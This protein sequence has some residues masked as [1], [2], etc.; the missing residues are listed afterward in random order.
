MLGTRFTGSPSAASSNAAVRAVVGDEMSAGDPGE[1]GAGVFSA[2]GAAAAVVAV[3]IS[4]LVP[5][6]SFRGGPE[7]GGDSLLLPCWLALL[8]GLLLTLRLLAALLL[9]LSQRLLLRLLLL[10][11]LLLPLRF[12]SK[13]PALSSD[14]L[15]CCCC[16]CC[17]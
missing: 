14:P 4:W 1:N 3:G 2:A 9:L 10:L 17:S 6:L 13:E 12:R 7:E 16:W 15:R 8:D 5:L 11:L